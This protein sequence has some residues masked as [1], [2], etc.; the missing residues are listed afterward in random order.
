MISLR[1]KIKSSAAQLQ[2]ILFNLGWKVG[3][4]IS[5]HFCLLMCHIK[6]LNYFFLSL[7]IKLRKI[8]LVYFY[9][10]SSDWK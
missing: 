10:V 8:S 6:Y 2:Y 1:G 3:A 7:R 9:H 4:T 5:S